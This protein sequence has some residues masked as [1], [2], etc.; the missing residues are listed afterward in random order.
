M[1]RLPPT[2]ALQGPISV[3]FNLAGDRDVVVNVGGTIDK[4]PALVW[5][6]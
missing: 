2:S 5:R 6:D 3:L 1:F 4:N